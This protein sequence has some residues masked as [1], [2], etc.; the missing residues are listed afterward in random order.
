MYNDEITDTEQANIVNNLK[1][2]E[3][4]YTFRL[5][6]RHRMKIGKPP[7]PV[8]NFTSTFAPLIRPVSWFFFKVLNIDTSFLNKSVMSSKSTFLSSKYKV[9][10]LIAVNDS[11]ERGVKLTSDF[12]DTAKTSIACKIP[13]RLLKKTTKMALFFEKRDKFCI[14]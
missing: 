12:D 1:Y 5:M 11:A 2:F 6:K 8:L 3:N 4:S 14:D 7:F 9:Q 10:Q 13:Y